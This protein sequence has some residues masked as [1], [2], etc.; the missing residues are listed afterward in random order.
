VT[1]VYP[2]DYVVIDGK[3]FQPPTYYDK[4]C[5]ELYPTLWQRTYQNRLKKEAAE[6]ETIEKDGRKVRIKTNR[7]DY[8]GS[9]RHLIVR[10]KIQISQEKKR[11]GLE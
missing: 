5:A 7:D 2:A 6:W 8:K 4:K 9:D 11:D 3:K 10:E 1:D